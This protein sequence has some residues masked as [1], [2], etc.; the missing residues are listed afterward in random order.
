MFAAL[1]ETGWIFLCPVPERAQLL[2][3][4]KSKV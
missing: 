2:Q 4:L 1:K 3:L